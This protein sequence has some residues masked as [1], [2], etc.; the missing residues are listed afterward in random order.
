[1][2]LEKKKVEWSGDNA[3]LFSGLHFIFYFWSSSG[4]FFLIK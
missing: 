1:M 2:L 4:T 3:L